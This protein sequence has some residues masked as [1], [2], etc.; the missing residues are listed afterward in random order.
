[1]AFTMSANAVFDAFGTCKEKAAQIA[2]EICVTPITPRAHYDDVDGRTGED[3]RRFRKRI[4]WSGRQE[5]HPTKK[6]FVR[7]MLS[8]YGHEKR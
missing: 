8:E 1:V 7:C 3:I 5:A 4:E 2:A 6:L